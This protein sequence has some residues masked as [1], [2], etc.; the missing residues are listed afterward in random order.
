MVFRDSFGFMMKSVVS[1]RLR[2]ALTSLGIGIG[3]TAVVL[4]T[5]VGEGLEAYMLNQFAQ[6]GTNIIAIQP[7]KATTLGTSLGALGTVRPLTIED[8]E[9][10]RRVPY[11]T[12][13]TPA[14]QGNAS[15][16]GGGKERRTMIF[17]MGR[18]A[19]EMFSSTVR[20]GTALPDDDPTRPRAMAVL[21]AKLATELFDETNPV[22]QRVRV[23][24]DRYR[25]VGVMG[26]Q[27]S[28]LGMDLDDCVILPAARAMQMFNKSSLQEIDVKYAENAPLEEVV[29]G[30]RRTLTARH[31]VD[32]VTILSQ[33]QMLE[34]LG[35]VL[36]VITFAVG[37]LGSISLLVGGVGIFTIMT[38]AVR[39]RTNEVGL[40]RAVGARRGQVAAIFLGESV[41]LGAVGGIAGLLV[42]SGIVIAMGELVSGL[43]VKFSVTFIIAAE[44]V[45]VVIGLLAGVL[46]AR[47][48]AAMDP[49]EALRAD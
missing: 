40:L 19:M 44:V 13:V 27:G 47:R 18:D 43:P 26:P 11:V 30:I 2:S 32:D 34:V 16:E 7:G 14:L 42:G 22:G 29:E 41:L 21:C 15:V 38:I 39:E 20:L 25:V 46:P 23:G 8:A 37:A 10:L 12:A 45:A 28:F 35:S 3:V 6:F 48:A 1:H 33:Q 36:G 4:L 5:S 9:A 49:V 17:G 24:G 31:G